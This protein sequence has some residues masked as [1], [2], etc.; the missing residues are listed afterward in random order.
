MWGDNQMDM[1]QLRC[2]LAVSRNLSFSKA[3]YEISIPQSLISR[4][5][6][7]LE[8]ELGVTLFRRSTHSVELTKA[9]LLLLDYGER[10][11]Q[12]NNTFMNKLRNES[13]AFKKKL[14]IG[15]IH[16]SPN[17]GI[18]SV[19]A[20]F[21][22]LYPDIELEIVE[23]TTPH[24]IDAL[25]DCSIDVAFVSSVYP[26]DCE[27]P[28]PNF[29]LDE[30]FLS[31][32]IFKDP[33]YLAV[34]NKHKLA[35]HASVDYQDI[36]NEMFIS[37]GKTTDVYYKA[38]MKVFE[39]EGINPAFAARC[40]SPQDAITLIKNNIGVAFLTPQIATDC[41]DMVLI[42]LKRPL[43]RDSQI[44][45]RNEKQMPHHIEKLF[46]LVRNTFK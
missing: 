17:S 6:K 30:R 24:L 2:F 34:S 20:D 4:K 18:M 10:L 46:D 32:T 25:L 43:I 13:N 3:S 19:I 12:I 26:C 38:F 9:G 36:K 7:S 23:S 37:Y 8:K 15:S 22:K 16:F 44:I 31:H 42:P 11:I 5:I 28:D 35:N 14:I 39:R 1:E 21:S 41:E 45:I 40:D 27:G 29:N 33:Y